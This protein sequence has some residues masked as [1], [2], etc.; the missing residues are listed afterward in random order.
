M[1]CHCGCVVTSAARAQNKSR[2]QRVQP[3][4]RIR[5]LSL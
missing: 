5:Q 2:T 1:Q 4:V 3:T